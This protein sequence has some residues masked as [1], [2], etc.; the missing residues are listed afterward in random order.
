VI[1]GNEFT[2]TENGVGTGFAIDVQ[3]GTATISDN[4]IADPDPAESAG[5]IAIQETSGPALTGATLTRNRI[6]GGLAGVLLDDTQGA[7]SLD[8][9]VIAKTTGNS[10]GGITVQNNDPSAPMGPVTISGVTVAEN[11]GGSPSVRID[12]TSATIDSSILDAPSIWTLNGAT[13]TVTYSN[14]P[15]GACGTMQS[16]VAPAFADPTASPPDYHLVATDPAN[17]PLIERGNPEAGSGLD[18]DGEPRA[19]DFD[20]DCVARRDIGADEAT[21]TPPAPD[22]APPTTDKT[23]PETTIDSGPAKKTK[24]RR[25]R[26]RFSSNEP[27]ASF[28]CSVD[29]KA[30]ATCAS[31]LGLRVKRRRHRFEVKAIDPAGNVDGTPAVH[32]WKVRK[33]GGRRGKPARAAGRTR[34]AL[35]TDQGGTDSSDPST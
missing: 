27:G 34:M 33:R 1:S 14:G 25:A 22:C 35:E 8:G 10:N 24:R 9:D 31:P 20:R 21:P 11:L 26:F 6:F 5:A 18:L 29:R 4:L 23:A 19:L 7:V 28:E 32:R 15:P 17:A 30:F 16:N 2:G 3:D 13:C 12:N